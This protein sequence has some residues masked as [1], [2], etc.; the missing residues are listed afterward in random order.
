PQLAARFL[1]NAAARLQVPAKTIGKAAMERMR[2]H[3]WP[4][5][6][7]Q[8]RNVVE[9]MVVVDYDEVLDVDDLL[10]PPD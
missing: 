4:G 10:A 2:M 3:D 6:V 1:A 7:R 8:L 9:S 5:N